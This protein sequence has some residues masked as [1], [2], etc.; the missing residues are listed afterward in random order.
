MRRSAVVLF[1]IFLVLMAGV[2]TGSAQS[3][4]TAEGRSFTINAGGM[5]SGFEPDLGANGLTPDEGSNW[6]FGGGTYVDFHFTHW[7]QL[8]GEARWLRFNQYYGEHEDNYLIGPRV[9]IHS[10]G[11]RGEVYGKALIGL[12]SMT[13]PNSPGS[14]GHF[15]DLAFGGSADFRVSSKLTVRAVDFEYQYWPVW[16]PNHSLSPYGVSVGASYRVF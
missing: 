1:C 4:E 7:L 9:P 10:I 11:R 3:A 14:W 16:L 8:E 13:F 15:T 2:R 12:G 6:L 5:V